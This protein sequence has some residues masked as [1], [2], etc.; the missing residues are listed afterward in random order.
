MTTKK[1]KKTAAKKLSKSSLIRSMPGAPAKKIIEA[2]AKQG[3]KITERYVYAIRSNA[4]RAR[5]KMMEAQP[6]PGLRKTGPDA[7]TL[8][9][10]IAELGLRESRAV[11]DA[12]EAKFATG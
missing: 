11:L 2:G 3:L 10:I 9:K 8:R 6:R 12:V 7:A 4:K 1:T 5:Q